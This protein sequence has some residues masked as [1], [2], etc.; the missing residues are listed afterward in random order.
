M[1]FNGFTLIVCKG[2]I[3]YLSFLNVITLILNMNKK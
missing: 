3:L 2:E 1:P